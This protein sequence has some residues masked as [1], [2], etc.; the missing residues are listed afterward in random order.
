MT[1]KISQLGNMSSIRQK[2]FIKR[3]LYKIVEKPS[4]EPKEIKIT[5]NIPVPE[6][7]NNRPL[8]PVP[9]IKQ[10]HLYNDV[11]VESSAYMDMSN[12]RYIN[13]SSQWP[14]YQ[15]I[16]QL[17]RLQIHMHCTFCNTS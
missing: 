7:I 4:E 12:K 5:T 8:P 9:R 10:N 11:K 15:N 13:I 2:L 3:R 6:W 1:C 14:I 16:C 17:H